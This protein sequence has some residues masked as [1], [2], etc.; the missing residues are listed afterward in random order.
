LLDP[1][2]HAPLQVGDALRELGCLAQLVP[3]LGEVE[4]PRGERGQGGR[5]TGWWPTQ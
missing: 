3:Q 4:D 5:L 2:A 1:F